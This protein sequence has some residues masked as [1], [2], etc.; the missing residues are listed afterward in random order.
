M[1]RLRSIGGVFVAVILTCLVTAPL[2]SAGEFNFEQENLTLTGELVA[3]GEPVF[4]TDTGEGSC[5]TGTFA[6]SVEKKQETEIQLVPTLGGCAFG[7][8]MVTVKANGCSLRVLIDKEEE[9]FVGST[10]V[11]CPE[12]K[13]I[14]FIAKPAEC[15]ILL[16][17]QT[18]QK[19]VVFEN[20][21]TGANR[22]VIIRFATI[23]LTYVEIGKECKNPNG[24]TQNGT[25][26]GDI[27]VK[28]HNGA[29][30]QKGF[31]VA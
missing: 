7:F 24:F 25:L 8:M 30:L 22:S 17:P 3:P 15:T 23:S 4:T 18:P 13:S 31:W 11:A 20:E 12:G 2:A 16:P 14:E 28:T 1:G 9:A 5:G 6:G 10:G 26:I 29:K 19:Q 21:G 27:T